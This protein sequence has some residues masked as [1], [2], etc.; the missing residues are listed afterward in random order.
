MRDE[1]LLRRRLRAHEHDCR[2]LGQAYFV[3]VAR[4][5]SWDLMN[6]VACP[7]VKGP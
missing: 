2:T 3:F 1:C 5:F 6:L 4:A 7:A